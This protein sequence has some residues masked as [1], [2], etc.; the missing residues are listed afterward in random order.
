MQ[1]QSIQNGSRNFSFL[2]SAH[3]HSDSF[4]P[5]HQ[6]L[7]THSGT[8]V[9]TFPGR[10]LQQNRG[11]HQKPAN[12]KAS[13]PPPQN[14]LSSGSIISVILWGLVQVP[15]FLVDLS[16]F[17]L[18]ILPFLFFFTIEI[19]SRNIIPVLLGTFDLQKEVEGYLTQSYKQ[20]PLI[21]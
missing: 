8:R 13:F 7:A 5:Y 2:P 6:Q 18:G 19:P 20:L 17:Y 3:Q 11:F 1:Q 12:I 10:R 14:C 16:K 9:G 15:G 21:L 4:I